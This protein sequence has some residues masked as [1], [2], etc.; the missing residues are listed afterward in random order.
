[1]QFKIPNRKGFSDF[2]AEYI[3]G[4]QTAT[5]ATSETPGSYPVTSTTNLPVPLYI[6]NFDGAYFYYLQHLGMD[7][8]QLVVKYDWYDP[9]KKVKGAEISVAKGYSAADIRYN[10]FGAGLVY[11]INVHV[12]ATLYYDWITNESTGIAGYTSDI[13]DNILTCRL[14]YRF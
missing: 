12:K 14:Q 2:R 8:L 10:T 13:K 7:R 11:Y 6:R 5:A 3:M 4:T 1:M 9:N